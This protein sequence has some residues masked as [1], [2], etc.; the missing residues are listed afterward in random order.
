M[1]I[2][3]PTRTLSVPRGHQIIEVSFAGPFKTRAGATNAVARDAA[4][5]HDADGALDI[6]GEPGA[7]RVVMLG[8]HEAGQVQRWLDSNVITAEQVRA[9][10]SPTVT[11]DLDDLLHVLREAEGLG[12]TSDE[13]VRLT[14][15][16]LTVRMN[17]AA[18]RER[19]EEART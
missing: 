15:A 19:N 6:V 14:N 1:I 4:W 10:A 18:E 3:V 7:W 17:A 5:A 12:V 16:A 8:V 9:L 13:F 2:T 11:V